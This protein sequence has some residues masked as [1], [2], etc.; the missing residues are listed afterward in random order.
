MGI[1]IFFSNK[2]GPGWASPGFQSMTHLKPILC[3]KGPYPTWP[4]FT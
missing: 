4:I 3:L 1:K 2:N